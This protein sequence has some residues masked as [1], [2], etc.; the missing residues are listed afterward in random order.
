MSTF[1][2]WNDYQDQGR[3]TT[4]QLLS[5]Y[6]PTSLPGSY[7]SNRLHQHTPRTRAN[8]QNGYSRAVSDRRPSRQGKVYLAVLA[9]VLFPAHITH[10][11]RFRRH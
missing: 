1:H 5:A 10:P 8:P 3:S 9:M 4:S 6:V 11:S 2:L 7:R